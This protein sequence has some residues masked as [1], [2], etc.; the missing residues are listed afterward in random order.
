MDE[1][2]TTEEI[3]DVTHA[4]TLSRV[5]AQ[6]G[7]TLDTVAN[8]QGGILERVVAQQATAL[9]QVVR[10]QSELAVEV[11]K[12]ILPRL[13]RIEKQVDEGFNR[14]DNRIVELNG[15]TSALKR[16]ADSSDMLVSLANEERH[17]VAVEQARSLVL[18]E[19]GWILKPWHWIRWVVAGA[20]IPTISAIAAYLLLHHQWL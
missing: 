5:A 1:D 19:Y 20:T 8:R 16:L 9:E 6:Q 3:V 17:R 2:K 14:M 15:H 12:N 11:N 4:S 13:G 7:A 10:Q 18:D